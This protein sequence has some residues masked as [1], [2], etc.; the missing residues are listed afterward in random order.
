MKCNQVHSE[1]NN[2]P[3]VCTLLDELYTH[4]YITLLEK[5]LQIYTRNLSLQENRKSLP[6][7]KKKGKN[8]DEK[9][10]AQQLNNHK[11]SS[12]R[13]KSMKIIYVLIYRILI[14][15]WDIFGR[16]ILQIKTNTKISV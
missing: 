10:I 13:R 1:E 6:A 16:L 7:K 9:Y 5:N 14:Y 3:D 15:S 2:P 8:M 4:V 11:A 12:K